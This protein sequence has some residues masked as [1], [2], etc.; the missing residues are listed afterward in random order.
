MLWFSKKLLGDVTIQWFDF[1]SKVKNRQNYD[2]FEL[3]LCQVCLP[4]ETSRKRYRI[5]YSQLKAYFTDGSWTYPK[6]TFESGKR[7]C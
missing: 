7:G 5:Y 1:K 3:F 2:K 6:L 4:S